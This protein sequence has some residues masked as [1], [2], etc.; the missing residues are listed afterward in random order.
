MRVIIVEDELHNYRLLKGMVEKLR[1]DWNIVEWLESVKS[2]VAWLENN[3]APDL[4]F[5]DIQLTDGIS[6][7]IFDSVQVDSMVIFTTAYD[8]Y[9]L[10]AFQ[11]NSI[12]YL[13][14][15]VKLEKLE[16]A[17]GKFE[18]LAGPRKDDSN[19]KPDYH[20]LLEAITQGE[21]KYRKRFLISGATSFFKLNVEDIAWFYT[22]SRMTTANTFTNK[23]YPIDFTMEKL[24]EQLDPDVFF[25]VNRSVIVHINAVRKFESHF[26]GKLILRLIPPFDEPITISRLKATEFKEWI[27]L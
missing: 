16:Q 27:G 4:I 17:I 15:P 24:E 22:E 23:Q 5:M 13:L 20:E 2:T 10:Q 3:P 21:K 25:R 26:G 19:L 7:S 1:P 18:H 12:D 8:E 14:K 9:A 6:F 11:V